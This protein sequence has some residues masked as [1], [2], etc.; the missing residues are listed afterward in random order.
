MAVSSLVGP[1]PGGPL[2]RR[3]PWDVFGEDVDRKKESIC[4]PAASLSLF[5]SL[6]SLLSPL[7][8]FSLLPLLS[9]I[10]APPPP[11]PRAPR[12]VPL[13]PPRPP[14]HLCCRDP[15]LRRPGAAGPKATRRQLRTFITPPG[16]VPTCTCGPPPSSPSRPS[17]PPPS[18]PVAC[19]PASI[20]NL[21]TV[22][23]EEYRAIFGEDGT[24]SLFF[25]T[26]KPTLRVT[27]ENL[28]TTS[29]IAVIGQEFNVFSKVLKAFI[30]QKATYN[31]NDLVVTSNTDILL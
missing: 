4:A 11:G 18:G 13:P 30:G 16:P 6:S 10:I 19:L 24:C 26:S 21:D 22:L 27:V 28:D 2:R 31:A 25:S 29:P 23:N 5:S 12:G 8:L 20:I 1:P 15:L 17:P 3:P 9:K 7:S 14:L